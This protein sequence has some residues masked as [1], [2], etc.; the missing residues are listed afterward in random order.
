MPDANETPSPSS[1]FL[2][3]TFGA[4]IV[5]GALIAYLGITGQIGAPIP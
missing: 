5:V 3:A 2:I 1:A 4:A